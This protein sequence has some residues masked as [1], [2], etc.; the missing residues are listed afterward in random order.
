MTYSPLLSA[1][2]ISKPY[3]L[4]LSASLTTPLWCF[5]T[6]SRTPLSVVV[7]LMHRLSSLLSCGRPQQPSHIH[8]EPD[9]TLG[10]HYFLSPAAVFTVPAP[11]FPFQVGHTFLSLFLSVHLSFSLAMSLLSLSHVMS[12]TYPSSN[13]YSC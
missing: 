11:P 6:H 1:S 3:V 2:I 12:I 7:L 5:N 13:P 10:F 9:I 8:L 4:F